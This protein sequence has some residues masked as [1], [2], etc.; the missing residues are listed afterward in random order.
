[1]WLFKKTKTKTKKVIVSAYG[2][3]LA[4]KHVFFKSKPLK[5]WN[6]GKN[7]KASSWCDDFKKTRKIRI[8]SFFL[9]YGKSLDEK[10]IFLNQTR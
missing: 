8:K 7:E 3:L 2:I 9:A 10:H 6:F 5:I 4:E 1:M